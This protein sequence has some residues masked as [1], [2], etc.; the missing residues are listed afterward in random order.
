MGRNHLLK[1]K[2]GKASGFFNIFDD[3]YREYFYTFAKVK[4]PNY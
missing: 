4:K 3:F 1:A 2:P